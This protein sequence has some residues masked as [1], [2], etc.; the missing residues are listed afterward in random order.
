MNGKSLNVF[1]RKMSYFCLCMECL[2]DGSGVSDEDIHYI[3]DTIRE[4]VIR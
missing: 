2:P 4:A 3:C 1:L